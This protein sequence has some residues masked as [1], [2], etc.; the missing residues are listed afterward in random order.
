MNKFT[1]RVETK[2]EVYSGMQQHV[3]WV[4]WVVGVWMKTIFSKFNL[5]GQKVQPWGHFSR[6][7]IITMEKSPLIWLLG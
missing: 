6:S 5:L 1:S 2:Q 7:Q 4:R 3:K